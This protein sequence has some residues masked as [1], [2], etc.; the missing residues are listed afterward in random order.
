MNE[1][2]KFDGIEQQT[3]SSREIA[4]L[5]GKE[6]KHVMRDIT[7]LKEQVSSELREPNFGL[8]Q[9]EQKLPTGGVKMMPMYELTKKETLLLVSGY[10][11]L[12]R[13]KIINRWEELENMN[14]KPMTKLQWIEMALESEKR[15]IEAEQKNAILMHVNK[16]YTSTELAKELGFSSAIQLNAELCKQKIQFKQNGTYVLY[17]QYAGFG[18]DQ[19]KQEVLDSGKVVYHRRWTQL[20]RNFVVNLLKKP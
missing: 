14:K 3:M 1:L 9:Y 10:N 20:G 4:E 8:S 5:T 12:L 19:I 13:L 16:T 7:V 17:S 18:Y 6:H 11:A 15:A 2:M